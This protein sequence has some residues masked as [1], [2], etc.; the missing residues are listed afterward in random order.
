MTKIN[1]NN[2]KF[3]WVYKVGL[4]IILTLPALIIPPYFFPAD[5]GKSIIF[6]TILAILSF[7]L[8][9]QLIYKKNTPSVI[10]IKNNKIIWAMSA[11]FVVFLLASIFSVD[12]TFSFWGSPFRGGGFVTFGFCFV[13]A[14]LLFLFFKKEDWKKAWIFSL[15]IGLLVSGLAIIQCYGLFSKIF[16]PNGRPPSTMGSSIVL[17]IYLLL[18]SFP[19]L[20][21]AIKEPF[22][23]ALGKIKK[24]FYIFSL[25]VFAFTILISGNRSAYLGAAIGVLYFLFFYP[26]RY[27]FLKF[28]IL[29]FLVI[30][31]SVVIYANIYPLGLGGTPKIF[32]NQV[33][34]KIINRLSIKNALNDERFRAWNIMIKII[35]DKPILGWGPENLAVGFDKNY[36]ST[37]TY[38]TWWDRAH[39]IFLNTGVEAGILGM[40]AQIALFITLLWQLQKAKLNKDNSI[41]CHGLQATIIGYLVTGFFSL[42]SLSVYLTLFFIIGYILYLTTENET[43]KEI[44]NPIEVKKAWWKPIVIFIVFLILIIFLWQYNFLPLQINGDINKAVALASQKNCVGALSLMDKNLLKNSFLDSYVRMEYIE[45][46]KPCSE[47]YPENALAYTNRAIEILSEAVKIQPLY[48][49]Y[50]IDLGELTTTLTDQEDDPVKKA[51]LS[52]QAMNYF[53]KALQLA[54]K[55]QEIFTDLAEL[56]IALGNYDK[57][58]SYSQKCIDLNPNISD[59]YFYMAISNIY[60]RNDSNGKIYL[61]KAEDMGAYMSSGKK[62]LLLSNAYGSI[63]DYKNMA[64][65]LEKLVA[66]SADGVAYDI[67]NNRKINQTIV[68]Y[69]STLAFLYSKMGQYEKARQ[70]ALFVLKISPESESSV[71]EFLKTIP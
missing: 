23:T 45:V 6:R 26:K 35:K 33:A 18:L 65:F 8:I 32:E 62:L 50:W 11:Y 71:T 43:K 44:I 69:H 21:F 70:E 63:P 36:S 17:A 19:T 51:A 60:A 25:A 4:F 52:K 9:Y 22:S 42:D 55:H 29:L 64:I 5:W 53:D 13:F 3:Y 57:A 56:E 39:N 27:K 16:V 15:F 2:T 54:P 31:S 47:Y 59:C 20:V 12:S 41:L 24:I 61:Q 46:E 40:L 67:K 14:L 38:S 34:E 7:L 68:Q 28:G 66:N 49:R 10:N 58:I 48:T 37:I 1:E 30:I